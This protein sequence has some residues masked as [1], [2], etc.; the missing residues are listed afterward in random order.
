MEPD[1]ERIRDQYTAGTVSCR[2]LAVAHGLQTSQVAR[3]CRQEGWQAR[4][5]EGGPPERERLE[6]LMELS[7]RLCAVVERAL[8]DEDQF[9][10]YVVQRNEQYAE[11]VADDQGHLV[12]K[13]RWTE[14]QTLPKVDTKALGDITGTLQRLTGLIRDLWERPGVREAHR[15][16]LEEQR[17]ELAKQKDCAE[18]ARIVIGEEAEDW[19]Q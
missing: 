12:T 15:M 18:G 17:L 4:R 2:E 7:D 19:A 9:Y 3:R 8:A 13:R 1:W 16:R 5:K 10:R 11:P 6:V 14:V